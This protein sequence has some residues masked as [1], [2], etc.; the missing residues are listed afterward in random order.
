MY[1]KANKETEM[2]PSS[3]ISLSFAFGVGDGD[4][5]ILASKKKQ[6]QFVDVNEVKKMVNKIAKMVTIFEGIEFVMPK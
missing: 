6:F 1:G 2:S 5:I 4:E 3:A